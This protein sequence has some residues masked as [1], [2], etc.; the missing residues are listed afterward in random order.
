MSK[1]TPTGSFVCARVI[2]G[3][4]YE[5]FGRYGEDPL[6]EYVRFDIYDEDGNY[7][8]E[9]IVLDSLPS[10]GRISALARNWHAARSVYVAPC[11]CGWRVVWVGKWVE[12]VLDA[13]WWPSP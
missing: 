13:I 6:D 8:T 2:D 12:L 1:E 10:E 4:R 9:D 3:V 5:I 11:P 7:L